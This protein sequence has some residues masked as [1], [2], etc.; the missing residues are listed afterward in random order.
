MA[1][2]VNE[3]SEEVK[4]MARNW[5]I[6][7][8][9]RGGTATMRVAG[10]KFL[11]RFPGEDGRAYQDRLG[12]STLFPAFNRTVS[13]MSGKPFAKQVTLGDD[14]P[15]K[16]RELCDDCDLQGNSLHA[17]SAG[18]MDEVLE[19]G[20]PGVLVDFPVL[21]KADTQTLAAEKKVGARPYLVFIRHEQLLGWKAQRVNGVMVFTQLRFIEVAEENDGAYGVICKKRV[22]VI[23]PTRWE[24]HEENEKGAFV[25]TEEGVNTLGKVPFVPFYG[26]KLGFMCGVSPLLDLA[27]LNVKHW[28]SQSDQDNIMHMARV[29]ILAVS[30][31]SST[32]VL[33]VGASSAVNLGSDPNAKLMFVEHTGAAIDAGEKAL[34]K[35]EAQMVQTGAELLVIREGD[36]KSATQSNNDA[37]ANKCDLQRIVEL[38]EDS[39]DQVL[40]LMADWLRLPQGGHASLFK[41]FGAGSLSDA[42]AQLLL[43]LQQGGIITKKRVI[44]EQQRRGVLAADIDPDDE[45]E[46]V[47]KDGPPLG[48]MGDPAALPTG[49]KPPSADE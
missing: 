14:V 33:T 17:F 9:L 13:V 36:Q 42:S 22:R 46:E 28:Q 5:P 8:A 39:L 6:V 31:V 15:P 1:L 32:F 45:L 23:E 30:G 18:L 25:L 40:Q 27:Y 35:L 10:D 49:K 2:Q 26:K 41:D 20:L 38:F 7:E 29:P 47:E 44:I 34:E 43:A 48:T 11:P 24:L 3:Q 21:D 16:I 4:A 19:F 12:V 37:E